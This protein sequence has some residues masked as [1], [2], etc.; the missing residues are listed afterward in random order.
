MKKLTTIILLMFAG[1]AFAAESI[2]KT[3]DA[4]PNG[5]VSVSNISGWVKVEGWDRNQVEVTGELGDGVKEF[6]FEQKRGGK[7]TL[8]K[9]KVPRFS[10]RNADAKLTIRVPQNSA[11]DISTVSADISAQNVRGAQELASVSGNVKTAAY[12]ADIE[13][14]AV[15]G[16]IEV[17][18]DGTMGE[19][20]LGSV[21]GDIHAVNLGGELSGGTVSGDVKVE[22][23]AY[24]KARL[25]TTS[26]KITFYAGLAEG[27][28]LNAESVNGSVD[29]KFS[30]NV[31]AEFDVETFNG[32]IKNCFGPEAERTS[33]FAPGWELRFTQG[34]GKGR[35]AVDTLNGSVRICNE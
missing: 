29:L 7:E 34:A 1:S 11:L 9:V 6:I 22:Q 18:G 5:T 35:V 21:S 2:D 20:E 33:E 30:G 26:G 13:L 8:I 23:G 31:D 3:M 14:E 16:D 25:E 4:D 19:A 12:G 27:G 24:R 32:K 28:A 17:S 10:A 15:S